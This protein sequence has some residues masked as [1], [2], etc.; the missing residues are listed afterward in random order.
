MTDA[1]ADYKYRNDSHASCQIS[2]LDL[3][4][5]FAPL[6]KDRASL[7]AAISGGGRIGFEAPFMPRNCDMRWYTTEEICEIF[8]RF[9]K[10][11][12]VGD[13]M[14]RHIVGALNVLLRKDL[15]YGAVTGWNFNEQE[16]EECFCNSQFDVKT[17]SVQGVFTTDSVRQHDPNSLACTATQNIDLTIELMLK[18]PL[19]PTE[20]ARFQD[21]L[22]PTK[23]RKPYAFIFGHGLWNDLDIVATENWL[24][25][26]LEA[27]LER[28]P[29]L[30]HKTTLWPRL[31]ISP[32]A[33]G[34]KKPDQWITSQGD[35]ALQMFEH[36]TREMVWEKGVE[37][38]GM[39]NMSIQSTK[40]DGVHLD[41]RGNLIK[42]MSVVGWLG[43]VG[44]EQ[45]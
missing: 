22:S 9:E 25:G 29:Y 14:M 39:W 15:G 43:M 1:F 18:F 7:L 30:G 38:L 6:C 4:K 28:A 44:V 32:N 13:S 23:P 31:F 35:K 8:G 21:L 11:I 27:T 34:L 40:Y 45:W 36:G 37:H 19:D 2:S 41:L 24:D 12:V 33:A 5:P 26:I 3:H 42:A 17:C 20:V 16:M 10:V